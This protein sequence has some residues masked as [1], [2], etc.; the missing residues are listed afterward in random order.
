MRLW[1]V[2][3]LH[4]DIHAWRPERTP[5]HDVMVIAGDISDSVDGAD[6]LLRAL[7]IRTKRPLI[8]VAGNHDVF[9]E[10]LGAFAVDIEG[11]HVLAPGSAAMIGGVRFVGATLWTD[12][13]LND[14]EFQAQAWAARHMPEYSQS[15]RTAISSGRA[16]ST[17]S[18]SA[19]A[20]RS[21]SYCSSRM[22]GRRSSS[23]TTPPRS[24]AC[25]PATGRTCRRRHMPA[26]SKSSCAG[27]G[28]RCGCTGT[29][30]TPAT[31]GSATREWCATREGISCPTGRS[32]RGGTRRW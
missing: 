24:R 5:D 19:T 12:W 25:I 10:R 26:I 2:S 7:H 9:G 22:P 16:T 15:A 29:S 31:I 30:I 14:R 13:Q 3:D 11:V 28:Q 27:I 1:I 6:L 23:R 32:G 4:T 20:V 21:T 17:T 18:T 8:F